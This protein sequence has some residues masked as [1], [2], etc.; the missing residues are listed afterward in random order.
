MHEDVPGRP[1]IPDELDARVRADY[2]TLQEMQP[3][4][5]VEY[6]FDDYQKFQTRTFGF[7]YSQLSP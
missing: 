6:N 1:G 2:A 4:G 3:E 5:T 7:S